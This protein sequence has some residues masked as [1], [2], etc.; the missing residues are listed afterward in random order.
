MFMIMVFHGGRG[1]AGGAK[2]AVV[3]EA[4]AGKL[5]GDFLPR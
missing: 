2:R 1:G 4:D 5:A 3:K